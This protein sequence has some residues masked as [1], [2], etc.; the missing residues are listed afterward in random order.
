MI[1]MKLNIGFFLFI[2]L[3]FALTDVAENFSKL[4]ETSPGDTHGVWYRSSLCVGSTNVPQKSFKK[5]RL[6]NLARK[7]YVFGDGEKKYMYTLW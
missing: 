6:I 1:F 2:Y 7:S 3:F 5:L 4:T